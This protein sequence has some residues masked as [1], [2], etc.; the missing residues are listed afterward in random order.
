MES[1]P[2]KFDVIRDRSLVRRALSGRWPISPEMREAILAR[3][4]ELAMTG[5]PRDVNQAVRNLLTM[6][7]QNQADQHIEHKDKPESG[8]VRVLIEDITIDAPQIGETPD[9]APGPV[10]H[11]D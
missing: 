4:V 1:D 2:G 9:P 11:S 5:K 7:A 8:T 3:M 6:E 10:D